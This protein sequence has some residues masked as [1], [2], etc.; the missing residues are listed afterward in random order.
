M[1]SPRDIDERIRLALGD[2]RDIRLAYLFGSCASGTAGPGSHV[3]VAILF[4]PL[5]APA[6]LDRLTEDLGA[7]AGRRVD[8][9][10]NAAE[11]VGDIKPVLGHRPPLHSNGSS[12]FHCRP[13][14]WRMKL[15]LAG[16]QTEPRQQLSHEADLMMVKLRSNVNSVVA[17]PPR[18]S[19][20]RRGEY[21][22]TP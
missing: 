9:V 1:L 19:S 3:D 13:R 8:L 15:S 22:T 16:F 12:P 21:D 7:A 17:V 18:V 2:Q 14:S 20:P 10:L 11:T 6:L 4:D 5:P